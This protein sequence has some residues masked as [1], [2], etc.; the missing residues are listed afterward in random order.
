MGKLQDRQELKLLQEA[1]KRI[2]LR[3]VGGV[4]VTEKAAEEYRKNYCNGCGG[5]KRSPKLY[6]GEEFCGNCVEKWKAG[7]R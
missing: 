4:V 5:P 7:H 6:F 1:R 2:T 3:K